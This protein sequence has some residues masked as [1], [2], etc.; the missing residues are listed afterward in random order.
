MLIYLFG[1]KERRKLCKWILR[2]RQNSNHGNHQWCLLYLKIQYGIS[3]LLNCKFSHSMY[4]LHFNQFKYMTLYYIVHI[5][6][7]NEVM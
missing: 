5:I 2:K 6:G 3:Y 7:F 4:I 1:C